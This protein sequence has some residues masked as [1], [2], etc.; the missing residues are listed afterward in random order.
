MLIN[1]D[2]QDLTSF[3]LSINNYIILNKLGLYI[4]IAILAQTG[5]LE[6]NIVQ[7]KIVGLSLFGSIR[8]M[9]NMMLINMIKKYSIIQVQELKGNLMLS[10][11]GAQIVNAQITGNSLSLEINY[12]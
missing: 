9:A 1:I 7:A 8:K 12:I 11:K 3:P 2:N 6:L 5:S 4:E 10:I